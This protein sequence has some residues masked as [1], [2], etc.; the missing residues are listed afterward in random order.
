[1]KKKNLKATIRPLGSPVCDLT[2]RH[3]FVCSP[4]VTN[5]IEESPGERARFVFSD[6]PVCEAAIV[7]IHPQLW[8][9]SA[10][11]EQ[12]H[13]ACVTC[14]FSMRSGA[15]HTFSLRWRGKK[16]RKVQLICLRSGVC[17]CEGRR[18]GGGSRRRPER[19]ET[20][21]GRER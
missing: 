18:G 8:Q 2:G 17:G 13:K 20:A 16:N 10:V 4:P 21:S 11:R 12:K 15:N 14:S 5:P 9:H 7:D 3:P 6:F 19:N 1:M